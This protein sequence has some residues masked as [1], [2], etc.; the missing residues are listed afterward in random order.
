MKTIAFSSFK[1]GTAKTSTCLHLGAALAQFHDQKVLLIDFDAQANLTFGLGCGM[2]YSP[3]I[4]E[5]LQGK[6]LIQDVILATNTPNL[7]IVPAN[8]Y[9]DG[10]ESTSPIVGDLYGHERLKKAISHLDF[11]LVL[12]DTPPSL[13][14]LT[15][16]ALFAS[17][18]SLICAIPEPYSVMALNR[19]KEIHAQIQEHH[20]IDVLGVLLTF[21]DDRGATNQGYL[22]AI[23]LAFPEKVLLSKIRRDIA[24]SRT[25]LKGQTVFESQKQ[26]RASQDYQLLANEVM[27]RIKIQAI[28]KV[29]QRNQDVNFQRAH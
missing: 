21:W 28:E 11:D 18:Y 3:S 27:E 29:Q 16:S 9:L 12:I 14:W 24:V 8:A 10:I 7:S 19:L 23:D 2:D 26:G 25:I 13:G 20:R 5:V 17:D 6:K 15:Q 4:V 1:G 22:E